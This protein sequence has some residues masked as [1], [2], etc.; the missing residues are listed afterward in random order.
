MLVGP[1]AHANHE[2]QE[3]TESLQRRLDALLKS[4]RKLYPR[5]QEDADAAVKVIGSKVFLRRYG[6]LA[7][8]QTATDTD[9]AL[10][11][12]PENGFRQRL[13]SD[14][15]RKSEIYTD[16]RLWT[17]IYRFYS[18]RLLDASGLPSE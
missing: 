14:W 7:E 9:I 5:F 4:G 16:I 10:Q 3:I 13:E 8:G 1:E 18:G 11:G 6:F 12:R 15:S 2:I 17:C